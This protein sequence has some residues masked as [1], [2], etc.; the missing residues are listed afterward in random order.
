AMTLARPQRRIWAAHARAFN[1]TTTPARARRHGSA[2][3][4]MATLAIL[5]LLIAAAPAGAVVLSGGPA[6]TGGTWSCTTPV[7]GPEKLT[8]GAT[9][10]CSGTA[11]QFTNLYIGINKNTSLPFGDKQNSSGGS[12]ASAGER[13]AWSTNG[14]AFIRYT[15][16]TTISGFGT[17]FT[18]ATL[19][20]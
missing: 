12:E 13:F 8:G 17:V 3:A 4:S 19:T 2:L 10:N 5:G 1:T 14:S 18:R 16:Q 15:G 7:G 11:G 9:Y 20:F 6:Y